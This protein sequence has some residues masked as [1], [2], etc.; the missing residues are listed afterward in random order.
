M[1]ATTLDYLLP[2]R[3]GGWG[4]RSF[5][6]VAVAALIDRRL[7]SRDFFVA[8]L[9]LL[10]FWQEIGPLDVQEVYLSPGVIAGIVIAVLLV[11][12]ARSCVRVA[13]SVQAELHEQ[14]PSNV[15]PLRTPIGRGFV[16]DSAVGCEWW[17][18]CC[19]QTPSWVSWWLVGWLGRLLGLL[20][21]NSSCLPSFGAVF[22]LR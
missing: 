22:L 9:V 16:L 6:A 14:S 8:C 18:I 10:L 17:V 13:G 7:I 20:L 1:C 2:A 11:R 3:V 19:V 5:A 12:G 21:S 4:G 15:A